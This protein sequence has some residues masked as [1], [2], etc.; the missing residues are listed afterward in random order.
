MPLLHVAVRLGH[1]F[2]RIDPVNGC[3]Y[4]SGLDQFFQEDK[5]FGL[6]T[7][8][9][10]TRCQEPALFSAAL[11]FPYRLQHDCRCGDCGKVDACIRQRGFAL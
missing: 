4:L 3:F 8:W 1:L 6:L 5:V 10:Q 11:C 9:S 7:R 2:Q